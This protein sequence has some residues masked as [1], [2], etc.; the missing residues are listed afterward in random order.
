MSLLVGGTNAIKELA[1]MGRAYKTLLA[2]IKKKRIPPIKRKD[3]LINEPLSLHT[4]Q[5]QY[6]GP[7]VFLMLK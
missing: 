6:G 1:Q 2:S 3:A 4:C 7:M 5:I